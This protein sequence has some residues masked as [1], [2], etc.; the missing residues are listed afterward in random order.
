M[1]DQQI[2]IDTPALATPTAAPSNFAPTS[3]LSLRDKVAQSND[4][5]VKLVHVPQWDVD[6][7][8]RSM[9]ARDRARMVQEA[10]AA[11][12]ETGETT[13]NFER[14]YPD[15]VILCSFDPTTGLKAFEESDRDMLL[16]RHAGAIELVAG[17]AMAISGMSDKAVEDAGKSPA[18]DQS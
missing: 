9:A 16:D 17:A 3:A 2:D 10:A 18:A 1:S 13:V 7:E 14:L 8:V 4:I 11:A 15:L 6:I 12:A 5:E